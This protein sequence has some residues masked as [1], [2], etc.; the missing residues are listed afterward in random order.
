MRSRA[1]LLLLILPPFAAC[2]AHVRAARAVQPNPAR[3]FVGRG[4]PPES[5]PL[6][7]FIEPSRLRF[8][9]SVV[10]RD[11]RDAATGVWSVWLEDETGRRLQPESRDGAAL[12]RLVLPWS[13][14]P[15]LHR[16]RKRVVP[17]W[18]AYQGRAQYTFH[19]PKLMTPDR[20]MLALVMQHDDVTMRF[21]WRFSEERQMLVENY[22]W[23]RADSENGALVAPDPDAEIAQ[24]WVEGAAH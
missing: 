23:S 15:G 8:D 20:K 13:L 18:D 9:V 21:E 4:A 3:A 1:V 7:I 11:E 14:S 12:D 19:A 24:T 16:E 10:E 22:G 5:V 2:S 6:Y 17:G